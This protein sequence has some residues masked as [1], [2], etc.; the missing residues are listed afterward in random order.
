MMSSKSSLS[1]EVT[2]EKAVCNEA[3]LWSNIAEQMIEIEQLIKGIDRLSMHCNGVIL[4]SFNKCKEGL[5][6]QISQ[7]QV[8]ADKM[9]LK[10]AAIEDEIQQQIKE[11]VKRTKIQSKEDHSSDTFWPVGTE[12]WFIH[13]IKPQREIFVHQA[14]E[15]EAITT[16]PSESI[17]KVQ[18]FNDVPELTA[19]N[20]LDEIENS[21]VHNDDEQSQPV[22][23]QDV[24]RLTSETA[25]TNISHNSAQFVNVEN[26]LDDRERICT[27]T[28]KPI[29][30][31][32]KMKLPRNQNKSGQKSLLQDSVPASRSLSQ[33]CPLSG[34]LEIIRTCIIRCPLFLFSI[35]LKIGMVYNLAYSVSRTLLD[36]L[37]E[38]DTNNVTFTI[39]TV[40]LTKH[41]KTYSPYAKTI[42]IL[43][44]LESLLIYAIM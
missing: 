17:K 21:I 29:K 28:L 43:R 2:V 37:A 24:N 9:N 13:E 18:P 44:D 39:S 4:L 6:G 19:N 42:E 15:E 8:E 10:L 35:L 3:K 7:I 36:P 32:C 22:T 14:F 38:I 20:R 5:L 41:F 12:S 27:K 26:P 11:N 34:L 16:Q 30:A 33:N 31:R 1:G 40:C 23:V 25:R